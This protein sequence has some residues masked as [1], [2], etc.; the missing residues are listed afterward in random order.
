MAAKPTH[1]DEVAR[2]IEDEWLFGDEVALAGGADRHRVR[3][4]AHLLD[5]A[6]AALTTSASSEARREGL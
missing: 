4:L 2:K 6:S 5:S 3:G 1:I